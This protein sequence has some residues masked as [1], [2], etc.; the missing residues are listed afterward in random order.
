MAELGLN[1][2]G[3]AP[4]SVVLTTG[5]HSSLINVCVL[6]MVRALQGA[7][8]NAQESRELV[9]N[10]KINTYKPTFK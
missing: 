10:L 8:A 3:L 1:P 2:D 5:S 7:R 6:S 9:A 4:G